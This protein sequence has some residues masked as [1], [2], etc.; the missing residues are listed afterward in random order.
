MAFE[1]DEMKKRRLQREQKQQ[2]RLQREKKGRRR[3][4][5]AIAVLV[6]CGALILGFALMMRQSSQGGTTQP[7]TEALQTQPPETTGVPK[8]KTVIHIAAAGDLNITDRVVAA[9]GTLYDY[10]RAFMDVTPLLSEA[11]LTVLN[12]EG[13]LCGPPYGSNSAPVQMLTALKQA[14]VDMVQLAN[15]KTIS[16]G[17]SGFQSTLRAVKES[18]L[19]GLG[20]YETEAE[21]RKSGGYT[22]YEIQ[23]V[24]VAFVAF[25]KGMDNMALPVGS[26]SCVNL[27]YTDYSSTY[28]KIDTQGI[29]R[30]LKNVKKEKPDII[31]ALLHWGSEYNDN[32]SDTQ[33]KVRKLMQSEGV[34]V[35]IGTH[36]HLLQEI[37]YDET[38]GSFVAYSLGD[39]FGDATRA[40]T[41]YSIVLDLEITK[42]HATGETRVTNYSYTP[43]FTREDANGL[44]RVVRLRETMDDYEDM[45][46]GAVTEDTYNSMVYGL[47]RI[48]Y[49]IHKKAK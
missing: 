3:I 8:G 2:E 48:E 24:K 46:V 9:G 38:T 26:E 34:D 1:M 42:D 29:T 14:G 23:G 28:K 49:R 32:H 5:I 31:I 15:S 36:P 21:F 6:V 25:T 37:V 13:N 33:E 44:L 40:G 39:F 17:F 35:I 45:H 11:D 10:T 22:M 12:L 7:T 27:L 47:S 43:I 20:A 19:V 4:L 41:E 18:G 16:Q 30:I